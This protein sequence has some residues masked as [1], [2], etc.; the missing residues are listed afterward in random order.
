MHFWTKYWGGRG[1]HFIP[2]TGWIWGVVIL[3]NSQ[4]D[5]FLCV[6]LQSYAAALAITWQRNGHL[7]LDVCRSLICCFDLVPHNLSWYTM[8]FNTS[9]A[10]ASHHTLQ[11]PMKYLIGEGV[12]GLCLNFGTSLICF[13][14]CQIVKP[15]GWGLRFQNLNR[16][17]VLWVYR[18]QWFKILALG[19]YEI[20]SW[21]TTIC[22]LS[23][24][25]LVTLEILKLINN[26]HSQ[27]FSLA[28]PSCS[29]FHCN[30]EEFFGHSCLG[31]LDFWKGT[32]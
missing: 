11:I 26:V 16:R 4:E 18:I 7:P 32:A 24:P 3:W 15:L 30:N 14:H 29:V 10:V 27:C 6:P 28:T 8:I 13:L 21:Q 9:A 5:L 12:V 2:I 19:R 25:Q 31:C 17:E 23:A 20:C 1:P 22:R